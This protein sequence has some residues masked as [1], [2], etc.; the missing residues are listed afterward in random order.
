MFELLVDFTRFLSG[1]NITYFITA[2]TLLGAVRNNDIIAYTSD[3]DIVIPKES[4]ERVKEINK[5]EG[6][7]KSYSFL[8]DPE[9]HNC[10]RVCAVWA[11]QPVNRVSQTKHFDWDTEKEGSD[12]PYYMDVYAE[13][14][15][16]VV[17][18][19][20]L[21]YPVSNVTI[22][23]HTFY[24]PREPEIWLEASYGA[25]WRVPDNRAHGGNPGK[26]YPSLEEA[27]VWSQAMLSLRA[28]RKDITTGYRL[29]ERATVD[30]K[31]GKVTVNAVGS[32]PGDEVKVRSLSLENFLQA[33]N[34][35][36]LS[37]SVVF[38]PP[39]SGEA[40]VTHY[41]LFW[42]AESMNGWTRELVKVGEEIASMS[43]C[44]LAIGDTASANGGN[45]SD[46]FKS[47]AGGQAS[48]TRRVPLPLPSMPA[49]NVTHLGVVCRN[50]AGESSSIVEVPL[51]A[52]DAGEN[53]AS[54][55]FSRQA[56]LSILQGLDSEAASAAVCVPKRRT[57][58][59]KEVLDQIVKQVLLKTKSD[60]KEAL[61]RLALWLG[62]LVTA[63]ERCEDSS[64]SA[65][66]RT[67]H[68]KINASLQHLASPQKFAYTPGQVLDLDGTSIF[69]NINAALGA[70]FKQNVGQFGL[71]LGEIL[72]SLLG[73][74]AGVGD[75][76]ASADM[77]SSSAS[78]DATN[79]TTISTNNVTSSTSGASSSTPAPPP[80]VSGTN[81]STT[82]V[83]LPTQTEA[84]PPVE[85][86][87]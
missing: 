4:W 5:V 22:R 2:G 51:L 53:G 58:L 82:L 16:F 59:S 44:A 80:Q 72:K 7:A 74:S 67:L 8:E 76:S 15:D 84:P 70:L 78:A 47:C 50:E 66:A 45:V 63:L 12:I 13:Q 9:E 69:L 60:M 32:K 20:H 3:L 10:G 25:E 87:A 30:H 17:A 37:G 33:Q 43:R 6:V 57:L 83:V 23:N 36:I 35:S 26:E 55:V 39:E 34:G 68:T 27:K 71:S 61:R 64:A 86:E 18:L 56:T 21:N 75:K 62:P 19:E 65:S 49:A 79:S 1:H 11:S 40:E 38:V 29:L 81:V 28:A 31:T 42:L 46:P 41:V 85:R 77:I 73:S 24:A 48:Q 14:M 52:L 54:V